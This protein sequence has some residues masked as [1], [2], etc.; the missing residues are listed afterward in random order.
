M[1]GWMLGSRVIN[2]TLELNP[3]NIYSEY[4]KECPFA[5]HQFTVL[6]IR[7]AEQRPSSSGS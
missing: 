4:T 3:F 2:N 6:E 5:E 7:D 1:L